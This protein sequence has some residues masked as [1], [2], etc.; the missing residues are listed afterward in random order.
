MIV[1]VLKEWYADEY[2]MLTFLANGDIGDFE[3][4]ANESRYYVNHLI[5]YGLINFSKNGYS[6]NT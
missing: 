6:F 2:D 5:G 3:A 4:F 1:D